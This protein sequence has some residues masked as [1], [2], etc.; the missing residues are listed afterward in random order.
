[1]EVLPEDT[2]KGLQEMGRPRNENK[3]ASMDS[4]GI[5]ETEPA[6]ERRQ[7]GILDIGYRSSRSSQAEGGCSK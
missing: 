5:R 4:A 7:E 2:G 6:Q 3:P 1:M